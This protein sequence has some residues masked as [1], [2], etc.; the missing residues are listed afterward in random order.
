MLQ[1]KNAV[2]LNQLDV[3]MEETYERIIELADE[4]GRSCRERGHSAVASMWIS[5]YPPLLFTA[6]CKHAGRLGCRQQ[7]NKQQ[8]KLV[9]GGG[10]GQSPL[11]PN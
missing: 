5:A 2:P 10:G 7:T 3:L 6:S 9:M 11:G 1:D 4:V 8:H